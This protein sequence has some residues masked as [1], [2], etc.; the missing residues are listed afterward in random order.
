MEDHHQSLPL[1]FKKKK[2]KR[3]EDAVAKSGE[4]NA[5]VFTTGLPS[6]RRGRRLS[7][8]VAQLLKDMKK[9]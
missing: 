6:S 9:E 1:K 8:T 2:K 7:I 3:K 5:M 4:A